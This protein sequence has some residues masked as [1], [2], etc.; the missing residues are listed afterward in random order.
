M[1]IKRQL[2][3]LISCLILVLTIAQLSL[4]YFFK[5]QIETEISSRGEQVADQILR[6][7]VDQI[8]DE[9]EDASN[10]EHNNAETRVYISEPKV[11]NKRTRKPHV[12]ISVTNSLDESSV[13][14]IDVPKS[15]IKDRENLKQILST[16]PSEISAT[17][18]SAVETF[19]T[20][21]MN[22]YQFQHPPFNITIEQHRL[23]PKRLIKQHLQQQIE[24]FHK[25]RQKPDAELVV[26]N[27]QQV[28]V[29]NQ[30][31]ILKREFFKKHS[32]MNTM[33]NYVIL[34]IIITSLISLLAVYWLSNKISSPLLSLTKGFKKLEKGE[35]GEQLRVFGTSDIQYVIDQ[36][37]QMSIQLKKLA[38]AEEKLQRH[39]HLVEISDVSKGIAHALRNPLHT[40]GLAIEQLQSSSLE[41]ERREKLVLKVR[42]KIQQLD[43][44][45]QALLT[46]SNGDIRRDKNVDLN[47]VV[48]DVILELKQTHMDKKSE[49]KV[50]VKGKLSLIKGDPNELRSVLHTL[51]FNSYDAC[52]L[53]Y[54]G[55]IIDVE[56]S[57]SADKIA[58][59]VQDNG[60][61]IAPDIEA[62]L[63]EPHISTKAEGA[64]MGLYL[65]KRIV[66][67]YYDGSLQLQNRLQDG[68]ICGATAIVNLATK[69]NK[70]H[71]TI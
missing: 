68:Q 67:L 71:G 3:I 65:S 44:N 23:L 9:K 69:Q 61:G 19:L 26:E 57:Q 63:F 59:K 49:L 4:L 32:V 1:T 20:Q 29:K 7:T 66:E 2:F 45:I 56:L 60:S 15:A 38:L 18:H 12:K 14:I 22:H 11:K 42:N 51:I 39:N 8:E 31:H 54:S 27:K 48:S 70:I 16:L 33:F 47:H 50:E 37:N 5:N 62:K 24:L 40:I 52:V 36:F 28:L 25:V 43:K 35:F 21:K 53:N 46:I 13:S 64:G 58:I 30:H 34:V 17:T 6:F 55:I 41:A 10:S